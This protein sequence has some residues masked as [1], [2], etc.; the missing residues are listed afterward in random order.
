MAGYS[1]RILRKAYNGLVFN[2]LQK[3]AKVAKS[4]KK[5]R[6]VAK[7]FKMLQKVAKSIQWPGIQQESCEKLI[8]AW[9]LAPCKKL[10][11]VAKSLKS[12]KKLQ[13]P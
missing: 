8:M 12:C 3:A 13:K 4:F 11:K 2:T 1:A 7:I 5:L 9:Y 10:Q 6:K